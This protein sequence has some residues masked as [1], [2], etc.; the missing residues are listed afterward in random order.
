MKKYLLILFVLLQ[1]AA[2][3]QIPDYFANNP[4]WRQNS[5]C[6]LGGGNF[7]ITNENY[8]YRISGDST[9][10]DTTTINDPTYHK[11]W[12]SG[13]RTFYASG[14]NGFCNST[15]PEEI[16]EFAAL[17]RQDG[18]KIYWRNYFATTEELLYDFSLQIGDSLPVN[19]INFF[20]GIF[21]TAIDTILIGNEERLSFQLNNG[22][23]SF[24]VEG[25]GHDAGFL[26][27]FPPILEC[28][29]RLNCYGQNEL[30]LF[31]ENPTDCDYSVGIDKAVT[32]SNFNIYPNPATDVLIIELQNE[33]VKTVEILNIN[34]QQIE[35]RIL[36]NNRN[37]ISIAAFPAG[38]Y[39]VKVQNEKPKRFVKF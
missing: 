21:I 9:I 36:L 23:T 33:A 4:V 3:A 2:V 1:F 24:L 26:Q 29:N 6:N 30:P 22:I 15:Q 8:V 10:N 39:F 28:A 19:G 5:Q 20:S 35:K 17:V 18:R 7:C 31:P 14:P 25:I 38:V 27:Y 37:E 11:I 34:A 12:K 32:L 16:Q 13:V